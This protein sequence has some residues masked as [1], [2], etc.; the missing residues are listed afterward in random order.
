MY[1]FQ[2]SVTNHLVNRILWL[3]LWICFSDESVYSKTERY[4]LAEF[5]RKNLTLNPGF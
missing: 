5:N 4:V 1:L 3:Q 2:L